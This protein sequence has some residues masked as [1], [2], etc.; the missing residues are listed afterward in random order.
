MNHPL[1]RLKARLEAA[2]DPSQADAMAAYLKNQFPFL[3]LKAPLRRDLAKEFV[4]TV[5]PR[6]QALDHGL[7]RA[8]WAEPEREYQYIA[9]DLM[10]RHVRRA[11]RADL[12]LYV[13]LVSKKSWWDTVDLLASQ[14][15]GTAL[16]RLPEARATEPGSWLAAEDMWLQRTALLYQ[17]K[18]RGQTDWP[19]LQ[20]FILHLA[21]S[22]AFFLT[23]AMGWA[24]RTYARTDAEAVKDFVAS[25]RLPPLTQREALKHLG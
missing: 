15:C 6:G 3:G 20:A 23:K 1:Q 2:A 9:L 14:L 5:I 8:L 10:A 19:R 13:S 4:Q 11:T 24:L 18:Y 12:D 16:L 25:H 7:I 22:R 17:L 21:D